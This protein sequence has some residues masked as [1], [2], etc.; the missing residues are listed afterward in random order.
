MTAASIIH[1]ALADGI[2]LTL[3][4][5]GTIRVKGSSSVVSHWAPL[6]R[7]H[8]DELIA[9]MQAAGDDW[10]DIQNQ[11]DN[12]AA[13]VHA[14]QTRLMREQG[15]VPARYTQPSH[16]EACGP[17]WPVWLWQ[18][19]PGFVYGCPWCFNRVNGQPIPRQGAG[20]CE[21][22]EHKKLLADGQLVPS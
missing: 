6:I 17:V 22:A 19:A 2:A 15:Q 21:C 12:L 14:V 5:A 18:G 13:F 3:S 11:P 20:D 10:P 7:Q 4:P 16:C 1:E 8:K 9:I